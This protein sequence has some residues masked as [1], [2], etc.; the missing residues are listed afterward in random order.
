MTGAPKVYDYL[1]ADHEKV[2][3]ILSQLEDDGAPRETTIRGQ[4]SKDS[5]S[6]IAGRFAGFGGDASSNRGLQYEVRQVHDPLWINSRRLI[7]AVGDTKG[8]IPY[9]IGQ[10]RTI[11][12]ELMAFDQSVFPKLMSAG[13][14]RDI[15]AKSIDDSSDKKKKT[16]HEKKN[17]AEVIQTYISTLGL[18]IQFVLFGCDAGFWFNINRDFLYL[19][20]TDIPLK[21]PILVSGKWNVLGIIDALPNDHFA[22]EHL[23]DAAGG[24]DHVPS[25]ISHLGQLIATTSIMF[26]RRS[27]SYGIKPLAIYREISIPKLP[28]GH[29]ILVNN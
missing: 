15:M 23:D 8:S 13:S 28:Q 19:N 5:R 7:D 11:S 16:P 21:H 17:E 10:I 18:G 1:Y 20:E 22:I 25:M 27:A 12:G 26:G 2:A 6:G 29:A 3:A 4:R 9:E 14:M 24:G